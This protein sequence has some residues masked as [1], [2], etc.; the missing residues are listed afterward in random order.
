MKVQRNFTQTDSGY[1]TVD[2]DTIDGFSAMD[3]DEQVDAID[4]AAEDLRSEGGDAVSWTG[5]NV[6]WDD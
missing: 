3:E 6:Q 1:V 2:T 5:S 4:C